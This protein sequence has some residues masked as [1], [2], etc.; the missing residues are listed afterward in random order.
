MGTFSR[1]MPTIVAFVGLLTVAGLA[2]RSAGVDLALATLVGG[3]A[4]VGLYH[5]AFG[6]T[7]A[8]RRIVTEGRG[9]GLRAQFLLIGLT[10]LV[11]YP[12]IGWGDANAWVQP[13]SVSL[14][15][16]SF[17]F[18]AG[19][20]FGGGCGS[21][22]LFTVGGGS[23]RMVITL[24]FF[25]LGTMIGVAHLGWWRSLPSLGRVSMIEEAG[26]I[27]AFLMLIAILGA[28]WMLSLWWE[29]R[30]HGDIAPGRKTESL[31]HGP[32]SPWAGALT[33]AA[34]G[35][36]T[37][38]ILGRP[39]GITQAF[40][41]WGAQIGDSLGFSRDAYLLAPY[42]E[43][44]F[45]RSVFAHSTGVMDFGI[46]LGALGAAGLAGRFAPVWRLSF[47]DVWTAVLGGLMM[48]YGARLGYGCNIGAYLGGLASGSLH[49][50]VWA[51]SAFAGSTLVSRLRMPRPPVPRPA[52]A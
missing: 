24:A 1:L 19:M 29:K 31:L 25:I 14:V 23:T 35:I 9:V 48:G 45:E 33:L 21:G 37:F 44:T 32:W 50:W 26:P 5:A 27:G 42:S 15:V 41:F 51:A 49:G 18:G 6:F 7:G 30:W 11:S 34:V 13:I 4:G 39:W 8:W 20:Q 2:W 17:L 40:A 16:G 36:L 38:L 3:L 52:P 43:R 12:L 46:M 10:A 22:T 28:L 47:K